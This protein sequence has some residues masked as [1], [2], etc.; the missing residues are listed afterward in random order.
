[1]PLSISSTEITDQS[2]V[3]ANRPP[4]KEGQRVATE[5]E[6][7]EFF[8]EAKRLGE[9]ARLP[10]EAAWTAAWDLY[11]GIYDWSA[12]ADW[13]SKSPIPKVRSVVDRA[14]GSFRR[15]LIRIKRFYSVESESKLGTQK[16]YFTQML[17]DYWLAKA[18]FVEELTQALKAGLITSQIVLKIWW[19]WEPEEAFDIGS[20]IDEVPIKEFGLP[21]GTEAKERRV[22]KRSERMVGK[23]G[24]KAVDPFKFWIVPNTNGQAVIEKA[25]MTIAD[26]EALA[27]KGIYDTEAVVAVKASTSNTSSSQTF[28][29]PLCISA[30]KRILKPFFSSSSSVSPCSSIRLII[31]L[32]SLMVIDRL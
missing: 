3:G 24:I 7:K 32:S 26:L 4:P 30:L 15:A 10:R 14:A 9:M 13:Q 8:R 22:I 21:V 6:T 5:Q 17:L 29:L 25:E 18:N 23:L 1:M 19:K 28:R 11:N 20:V 27:A 31:S 16:G 12:K 2:K